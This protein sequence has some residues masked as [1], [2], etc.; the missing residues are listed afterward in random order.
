MT[1]V[2][3]PDFDPTSHFVAD[4]ALCQVRLNDDARF[5]WLILIPR[6]AA[7][8]DFDDLTAVERAALTEETVRASA[9]VRSLGAAQ[10]RPVEKTNVAALGN[11]TPQLHVHV[12]GR[13]SDDAAWPRP[14]WGVGTA[15]A[16]G[17][18]SLEA[19]LATLGEALSSGS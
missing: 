6:V 7:A 11:V 8:R 2:L 3:H 1:F 13:R 16:Y 19:W 10:G 18:A 17:P 4:L 15:E 5:P 9:A 12:I 14:V